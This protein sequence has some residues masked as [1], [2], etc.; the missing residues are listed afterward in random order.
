[1]DGQI[2]WN[3]LTNGKRTYKFE[4]GMDF[5]AT[6]QTLIVFCIHQI[7]EKKM[8]IQ[9]GCVFAIHTHKKNLFFS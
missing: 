8:G 9:S 3:D 5:G 4:S 2:I 6:D 7:I 1:L